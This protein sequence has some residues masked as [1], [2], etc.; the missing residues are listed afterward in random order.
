MHGPLAWR[1]DLGTGF[2]Q[3]HFDLSDARL[4][5]VDFA[6]GGEGE[7]DNASGNE[8]AAIG[9]FLLNA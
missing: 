2:H 6:R 9:T 7:I 8:G 3:F 1:C 5:D 4:P